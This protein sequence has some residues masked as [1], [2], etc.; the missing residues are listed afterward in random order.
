MLSRPL[1]FCI[2]PILGSLLA[3]S[4]SF[5][6]TADFFMLVLVAFTIVYWVW[7]PPRPT[8]SMK[9]IIEENVLPL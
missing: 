7:A 2:G 9:R 4:F 1:G 5:G 8:H 3:V 6:L